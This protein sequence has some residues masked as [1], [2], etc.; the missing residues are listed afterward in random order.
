MS[1]N[2]QHGFLSRNGRGQSYRVCADDTLETIADKHGV[3]VAALKELN[4]VQNSTRVWVGQVLHLPLGADESSSPQARSTVGKRQAGQTQ[5]TWIGKIL[6]WSVALRREPRRNSRA[7]YQ[8]ILA[9][10]P[11]D[12]RVTVVGHQGGWLRVETLFRGRKFAGYVSQELVE[13]VSESAPQHL[14]APPANL[15]PP[16]DVPPAIWHIRTSSDFVH[17]VEEVERE[18]PKALPPEIATEIRQLW[19][20]DQNWELLVAG[21]GVYDA[22]GKAVDIETRP[23]PIAQKFDMKD[24]APRAGGKQI[25][26]SMGQVDIGHVMAGIDGRLNGFP[27][28][29]PLAFLREKGHDGVQAHRKYETLKAA[30]GGDARDFTTWAGDLG[31]AYA[32]YLLS[33][34]VQGH[35]TATLP[36]A[37]AAKAADAQLLGDIHGYI[38]VEVHNSVPAARRPSGGDKVSN[39][40]R[41][42]YLVDESVRGKTF[43]DYVEQVSGKRGNAALR[44]FIRE[45]TLAFAQP[46]FAKQAYA[47]RGYWSSSGWFPDG[48]WKNLT[49]EFDT[50]H[51]KN[52][53]SAAPTDKLDSLVDKFMLMLSGQLK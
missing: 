34:Y 20:S 37:L 8:G 45:R 33:R 35:S 40:L 47:H 16:A 51:K 11:R 13:Y 43:Q 18:Y 19:F 7:P 42:M 30:S 14:K 5:R 12:T 2:N 6:P 29:Y 10:L 25:S 17:F 53:S 15:T 52:E 23:N 48:I 1:E 4:G 9:D 3:T 24:L 31:Q 46:W 26:T 28:A 36:A 50:L 49:D 27:P 32:E 21:R 22:A 41:S 39:I 38:A 44:S